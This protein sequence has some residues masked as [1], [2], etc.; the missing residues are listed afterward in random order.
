MDWSKHIHATLAETVD[1]RPAREGQ[2][3]RASNRQDPHDADGLPEHPRVAKIYDDRIATRPPA[4][5]RWLL[6]FR[7]EPRLRDADRQTATTCASC[8]GFGPRHVLPSP[9]GDPRPETAACSTFRWRTLPAKLEHVAADRF[10]AERRG[11]HGVRVRLLDRRAAHIEHLEGQ[12]GDFA[13]GA[14]VVVD[15]SICPAKPSGVACPVSCCCC[16]TATR[17]RVRSIL[18][19]PGALPA[20]VRDG[21]HAGLRADDASADVP[22][23]APANRCAPGASR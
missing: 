12:F 11:R 8:P 14:Q 9:R 1:T 6:G 22:H 15:Q 19:A 18:R 4:R 13:N 3:R 23:A 7:R 10:A 16:R 2:A 20:V 17:A 21:Q 5:S